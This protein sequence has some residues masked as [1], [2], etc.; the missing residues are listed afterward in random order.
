VK[1]GTWYCPTIGVYYKGWAPEDTPGGKRDRKRVA[2]HGPSFQKALKAG[3][4]IVFGTD[5]G[6]FPWTEPL[7]PELLKMAELG[8]SPAATIRSATSRA[9]EMLNMSGELGVIAPGALADL[10]AVRGDPLKDLG[11][12]GRVAFV[13]K[14]GQ[15]FKNELR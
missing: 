1:Q 4:R 5:V 3:V 15:V 12:L 9:A 14:A 6:G 8:M 11:E 10:I 2:V 7:A 13:M